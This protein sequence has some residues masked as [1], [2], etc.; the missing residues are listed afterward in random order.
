MRLLLL[1]IVT[2]SLSACES[3]SKDCICT[4]EYNPV[5]GSNGQEYPNPCHAECDG[6]TYTEGKCPERAEMIVRDWGPI[7]AD[8]CGWMLELDS[9]THYH[10][11]NLDSSYYQ[12][13]LQIDLSYQVII[14]EHICGLAPTAYPELNVLEVY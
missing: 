10:P 3:T 13:G 4:E 12:N 5:C 9:N 8:G 2:L 7:G 11:V 6:V 14:S 1:A